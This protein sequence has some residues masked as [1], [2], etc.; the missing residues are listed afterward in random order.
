MAAGV[1]ISDPFH[2]KEVLAAVRRSGGA[3][4][5]VE[6]SDILESQ[7]QLAGLG[8]YVEMTSAL[9]WSGLGQI[10]GPIPEPIICIITGH[11]LKN[12]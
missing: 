9:V 7:A 2:G 8:V 11:G 12:G 6:E 4:L 10:K 5:A 1:S 3:I